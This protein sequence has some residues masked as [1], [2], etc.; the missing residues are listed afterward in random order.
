MRGQFGKSDCQPNINGSRTIRAL[1]G[2]SIYIFYYYLNCLKQFGEIRKECVGKGNRLPNA[3]HTTGGSGSARVACKIL[4]IVQGR[5]LKA[6]M[7]NQGRI[8]VLLWYRLVGLHVV[9]L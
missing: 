2:I 6:L 4:I 7:S 9:L 5:R 8:N 1:V 3:V